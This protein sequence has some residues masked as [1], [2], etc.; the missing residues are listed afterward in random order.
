MVNIFKIAEELEDL[1]DNIIRPIGT[2]FIMGLVAGRSIDGSFKRS[3]KTSFRQI[4]ASIISFA[5]LNFIKQRNVAGYLSTFIAYFY[6]SLKYGIEFALRNGFR[7]LF[8]SVLLNY[9]SF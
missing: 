1:T 5:L 7:N 9:F 8:Y 3:L 4:E 6:G 2:N